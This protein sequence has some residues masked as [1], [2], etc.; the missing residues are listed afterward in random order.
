MN[1]VKLLK[2]LSQNS[3]PFLFPLDEREVSKEKAFP[4]WTRKMAVLPVKVE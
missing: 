1:T 4:L 2:N 3:S